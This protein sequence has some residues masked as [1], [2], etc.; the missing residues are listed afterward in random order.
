MIGK[1][2]TGIMNL[3]ISLVS[4]L[5]TPI[6]LLIENALPGLDSAFSAI[7]SIFI[8]ASQGIGWAISLTGISSEAISLI[9]LYYTFKLTVPLTVSTI[10]LALKWYNILKP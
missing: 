4:V 5:L 7:A 3:I 8:Y 1:I 2:L 10:K 6:D 9:I